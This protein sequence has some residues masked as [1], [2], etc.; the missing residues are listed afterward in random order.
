MTI[1][2]MFNIAYRN[3]RVNKRRS[4]FTMLGIIIGML[5]VVFIMSVG[6]G[7]Q[8]LILHQIQQR[9]TDQIAILAGAS[10]PNGPPAQVLGIVIT[11]LTY[12]DGQALLDK[13]NAPHVIAVAGYIS[14]TDTLQWQ[15]DDVHVTFTG[16]TASYREVEK[17]SLKSGRFFDQTEEQNGEHVVVLGSDISEE[18]FGNHYPI[19]EFV[20]LKGKRFK[21]IGVLE[22]KGANIFEDVDQAVLIP[23]S[24]AQR[25]ILG[26]RHVSFL[27][28]QVEGEE[29][30]DQTIADIRQ[31]IKE[32]HGDEDFS[33]RNISD[34]LD[35]LGNITNAMK[36][37]LVA[38]AAVS[39]FV[40]GIGIMNIMLIAVREKTR[41]IGL[42]K[43][44]GARDQDILWQFLIETIVLSLVGT[45]VGV[46]LGIFFSLLVALVVRSFG[47][48]YAFRVSPWI[49]FITF[50]VSIFIGLV[51]G[52][53]P[54]KKA[55]VLNPIEALRYE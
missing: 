38:I 37:F 10:D 22:E 41:E 40:G 50:G 6:A 39:L 3:L 29:F 28:L 33:V 20:K 24:V 13:N 44:V 46:V 27:R 32:R 16:T 36:F 12:E 42:R 51:F 8:S 54:A 21:I 48:V 18:I 9:G 47:Y 19:G 31:T 5:S 4:F 30:V 11:T 35:I 55:A 52:I 49:I 7:V 34:A 26:L 43:A 17:V 15:S 2:R 1:T 53:A 14:G 25:E 45:I 23:L